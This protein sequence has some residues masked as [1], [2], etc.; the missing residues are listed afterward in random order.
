MVSRRERRRLRRQRKKSGVPLSLQ[1]ASMRSIISRAHRKL[2]A[3]EAGVRY[4]PIKAR[5]SWFRMFD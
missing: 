5:R 3:G 2:Y 1:A 4:R